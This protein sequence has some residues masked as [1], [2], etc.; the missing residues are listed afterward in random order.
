MDKS[1][2]IEEFKFCINL[3]EKQGFCMFGEKT[4]CENC[5]CLYL[6]YKMITGD[7]IHGKLTLSDWKNILEKI[8]EHSNII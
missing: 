1:Q 2:L 8:E 5:A 3:W 6:L 7:I 4:A